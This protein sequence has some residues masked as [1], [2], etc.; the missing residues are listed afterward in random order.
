MESNFNKDFEQYVKQN[1][2]Q[3]RMFPSDKVWR[4]VNS[5]LHTRRK[6]YG[7]WLGFILLTTGGA[8]TWVMTTQPTSTKEND[9]GL[10]KDSPASL[11]IDKSESIQKKYEGI[12]KLLP[13]TEV[14]VTSKNSSVNGSGR[15]SLTSSPIESTSKRTTDIL[16]P[17]AQQYTDVIAE[18]NQP[19][20]VTTINRRDAVIDPIVVDIEKISFN[21]QTG[22]AVDKSNHFKNDIYI[23]LTIESVINA[24]RFKKP[25]KKV[26]W[27][28]FITPTVSYRKLS[29]NK[30]LDNPSASN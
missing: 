20:L 21:N 14:G 16:L 6:W 8:V 15:T 30:S 3:Y 24:Y 27:Q 17:V 26:S 10:L 11:T 9:I 12:K 7:F 19:S 1:A 29:L 4:G 23:P 2:D 5:A 25:V 22:I 18:A 13:F 28:L